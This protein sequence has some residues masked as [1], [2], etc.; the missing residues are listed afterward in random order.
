MSAVK[1]ASGHLELAE[2]LWTDT[3]TGRQLKRQKE[4]LLDAVRLQWEAEVEE[5]DGG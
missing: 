3:L 5:K 2:P 1:L 4:E